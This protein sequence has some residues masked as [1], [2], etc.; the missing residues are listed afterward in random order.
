MFDN[1]LRL[2]RRDLRMNELD[3]VAGAGAGGLT[4]EQAMNRFKTRGPAFGS[5]IGF[6]FGENQVSVRL[7][8]NNH[9]YPVPP[10]ALVDRFDLNQ[11]NRIALLILL[12]ADEWNL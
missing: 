2:P 11:R 4:I 1:G 9:L 12:P 5:Q 10:G 7:C 6:E 3:G 8:F